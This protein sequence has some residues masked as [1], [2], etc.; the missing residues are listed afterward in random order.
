[1]T[2]IQN[3]APLYA[4]LSSENVAINRRARAVKTPNLYH[5]E[6]GTARREL[7]TY[8]EAK[9]I[10]KGFHQVDPTRPPSENPVMPCF[11]RFS[12]TGN[13]FPV[14]HTDTLVDTVEKYQPRVAFAHAIFAA[15]TNLG[16]STPV[17]LASA[18][19]SNVSA[20]P[21]AFDAKGAYR[22]I[23]DQVARDVL[24]DLTLYGFTTPSDSNHRTKTTTYA[25]RPLEEI[26]SN[27]EA[28]TEATV[29]HLALAAPV[30][31]AV[32]TVVEEAT[33]TTKRKRK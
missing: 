31:E 14:D 18:V 32:A 1:M 17:A 29:A 23:F 13:P 2:T 27:F 21:A 10:E 30:V 12:E 15:L 7:A 20:F 8:D 5:F 28:P 11:K 19:A 33:A 25:L 6:L 3:Q 16:K 24:R 26:I 9:H 22:P 4:V